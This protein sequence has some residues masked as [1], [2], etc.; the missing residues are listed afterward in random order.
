MN[1][2]QQAT[3]EQLKAQ[4]Y[5]LMAQMQY[6]QNVLQ[7]IN[8]AINKKLREQQKEAMV[9]ASNAEQA[10]ELGAAVTTEALNQAASEQI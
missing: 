2:T 1:M 4:A 8:E 5:D 6:T 10:K 9:G 7:A 3:L